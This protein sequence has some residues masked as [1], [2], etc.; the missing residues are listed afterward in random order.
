MALDLPCTDCLDSHVGPVCKATIHVKQGWHSRPAHDCDVQIRSATRESQCVQNY[1]HG[2][3]IKF[4]AS[5]S[6]GVIDPAFILVSIGALIAYVTIPLIVINYVSVYLLGALSDVYRKACKEEVSLNSQ[7]AG[8]GARMIIAQAVYSWVTDGDDWPLRKGLLL[9]RI[10]KCLEHS[11]QDALDEQEQIRLA[12]LVVHALQGDKEEIG[13]HQFVEALSSLDPLNCK[14]TIQLFDVDRKLGIP[15]RLFTSDS[16]KNQA[17]RMFETHQP[18]DE[19]MG[20]DPT[21]AASSARRTVEGEAS[22]APSAS[23]AIRRSGCPL[24]RAVRHLLPSGC[25]GIGVAQVL[26][27]QLP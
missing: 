3:Q 17:P 15:E 7:I 27:E 24:A 23:P 2:I 20:L 25:S 18:L 13:M 9:E 1:Y 12:E 4:S 14:D 5:G 11:G 8:F 26:S 10:Q 6:L 22:R 19:E 21:V 16:W